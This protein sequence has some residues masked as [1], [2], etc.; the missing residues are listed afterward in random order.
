M[1]VSLKRL[2]CAVLLLALGLITP[3]SRLAAEEIRLSLQEGGTAAWEIAAMQIGGFDAQN[4]ITINLR[5]AADSKATQIAL[6]AGAVDAILSDFVW[7]SVQRHAGA[8]FTFVPHSLAVGGL[9]VAPDGPI[10]SV[11]DLQGRSLAIAGGPVDKSYLIL[12]A[13]FNAKTGKSLPEAVSAQFGAPPLVNELL[14]NG[15]AAAALNF[16][17]FNA[18][19]R[20]A[21]MQ[22]LISVRQM[23]TELGVQR[24]PPLLGWVFSEANAKAQPEM[25]RH[26]LDASFATKAALL[27][28]DALWEKIRPQ[29]KG[30]EDQALFLALRDA[31]RAGIVQTFGPADIEAAI[32]TYQLMARYGG[33]D[34]IG[35]HPD[36]APGTFWAGYA[37]R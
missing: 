32:Q 11:A 4:G 2:S 3:A 33:S 23:L 7:V 21:G 19:A 35:N 14:A 26:F 8:D 20:L 17:H 31:Y 16:W 22:E 24:Q 27:R 12:Q 5:A 15:E 28:D 25:I 1:R 13:Y 37:I 18:R 10:K 30:A 6:Q 34:L 9:M 36:L 29:I